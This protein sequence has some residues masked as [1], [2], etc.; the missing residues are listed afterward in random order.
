MKKFNLLVLIVLSSVLINQSSVQ[1]VQSSPSPSAEIKPETSAAVVKNDGLYL[2]DLNKAIDSKLCDG[3]IVGPKFS[4]NG[5]HVV[6]V[7]GNSIYITDLKGNLNLVSSKFEN[8]NGEYYSWIDNSRIVYSSEKGGLYTYD[9]QKGITNAIKKGAEYYS[10]MIYIS[11]NNLLAEKYKE[12]TKPNDPGRYVKCFGIVFIDLKTGNEEI[13]I[14]DIPADWDEDGG[15]GAGMMPIIAGKSYDSSYVY[16]FKHFHS[17]SMSA[18]GVPFGVYDVKNKK[19]I[20]FDNVSTTCNNDN[21]SPSPIINTQ[22]AF[23][24]TS[25]RM[26]WNGNSVGILDVKD[27]SFKRLSDKNVNAM[28]PTFSPDGKYIVYSASPAVTDVLDGKDFFQKGRQKIYAQNIATKEVTEL[29][30]AKDGFDFG[31]RYINNGKT[32]IFLRW[33]MKESN[34][35]N[36]IVSL[37]KLE[38]GKE[39]LIS[40]DIMSV[41][42]YGHMSTED[43]MEIK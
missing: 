29:T 20:S 11:D 30:T 6:F 27:H 5:E 9:V 3:Q 15:T 37:W 38:N 13:V 35:E 7:R 23:T 32:L 21:I 14:P 41:A 16:I 34:D 28:T 26:I 42:Y 33:D 36:F 12:Y 19:F 2:V 18:D 1:P 24:Q 10:N 22:L 4:P 25:G 43:Y 17:G 39:T 31:P 8:M 40:K